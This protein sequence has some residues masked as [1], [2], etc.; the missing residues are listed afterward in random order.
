MRAVLP[1]ACQEP[2]STAD[3]DYKLLFR[4][5]CPEDA[6]DKSA[7]TRNVQVSEL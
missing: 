7:L 1:C 5:D 3:W 6:H 4:Q 2:A